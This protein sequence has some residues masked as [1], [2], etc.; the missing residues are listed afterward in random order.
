MYSLP[1]SEQLTAAS[2]VPPVLSYVIFISDG[3]H[4]SLL[5]PSSP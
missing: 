1:H 4:L 5:L 2:G 3:F